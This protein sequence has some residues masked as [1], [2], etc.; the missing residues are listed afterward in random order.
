[1]NASFIQESS[2]GEISKGKFLLSR[3]GKMRVEY[4][5]PTPLLIIANGS[6]LAYTDLEL[7]ETS[8]LSTN[9]TPASFLTR[10]NFSFSAKDVEITNFVKSD[11]LIKV[12]IVKKNKKEAG[13]FSLIFTANPLRFIKM[14]VKN[15]LDE[16]TKVSFVTAKFDQAIDNKMFVIKNKNL[17]E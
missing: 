6:V 14:E 17:P 5:K 4:D 2:T 15:D 13:V 1:M 3:P 9:S 11:N 10:K 12:G 8:Y 16:I 7:E